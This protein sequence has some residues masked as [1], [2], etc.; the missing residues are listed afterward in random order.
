MGMKS[1]IAFKAIGTN[2]LSRE[3]T[4]YIETQDGEFIADFESTHKGMGCFLLKPEPEKKYFAHLWYNKQKYIIPIPEALEGGVSMRMGSSAC[5]KDQYLTVM[6]SLSATGTR[7]YLV[8]SAYG[9]IW[10]SALFDLVNDSC[11]LRIPLELLPEGI[12]RLTILNSDFKPEC[13]RLIYT[14]KNQTFKIAPVLPR[15][16]QGKIGRAHV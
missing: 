3:V 7:K 11:R 16:P 10:F 12:C 5:G 14:N 9:K 4:G 1:K 2:G 8:G 6:K 13:E 15:A